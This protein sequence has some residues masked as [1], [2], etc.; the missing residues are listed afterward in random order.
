MNP[1]LRILILILGLAVSLTVLEVRAESSEPNG[2]TS[3]PRSEKKQRY[4][5]V[6]LLLAPKEQKTSTLHEKIFDS[7]ISKEFTDRYEQRFGSSVSERLL[8]NPE[9]MDYYDA[10]Q[11]TYISAEEYTEQQK[12]FGEYMMRRLTEYHFDNY[13]KTNEAVRPAY[14]LKEK[15]SQAKVKVG[16]SMSLD[17][18]YSFS[19]NF[20]DV[21]ILNP[22]MDARVVQE[23]SAS[24]YE[25]PETRL[26][27]GY[28]LN[29]NTQLESSLL[30]VDGIFSLTTKRKLN[31]S[32]STSLTGST[33]TY[34]GG[35]TEREHRVACAFGWIY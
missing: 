8:L 25:K 35:Y 3:N 22:Y 2:Y 20:M 11:G 30:G 16:P 6:F 27:L 21:K 23:F 14:E 33:Y 24:T 15:I 32:M 13:A 1:I 5:E 19:G 9:H 10:R 17:L 18:K 29:P 12:S 31:D 28:A 34:R 4:Y 7:K 26:F